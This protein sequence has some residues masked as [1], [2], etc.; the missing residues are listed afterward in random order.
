MRAL[1]A[2]E[3]PEA[4]TG[5][6]TPTVADGARSLLI[7]IAGGAVGVVLAQLLVDAIS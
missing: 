5:T 2:S 3:E 1:V 7:A 6:L 4:A